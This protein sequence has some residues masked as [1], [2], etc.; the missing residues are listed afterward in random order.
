[1]DPI[2]SKANYFRVCQ[3]LLDKGG[4]ALRAALK[5]S[6]QSMRP[7]SSLASALNANRATLQGIRY[8]I[9]KAP[10][11]DLLFPISGAPDSNNFDITLLTVLLRNICGLSP[12]A[13]GW[14]V[15]PPVSDTSISANILRVKMFRNEVYAHIPTASLDDTTFEKLW[16][17]ISVLLVNLGIPQEDIDDLKV[18]PLSP[19]EESYTERLKEWK[20]QEDD[21][22]SELSDVKSEVVKLRKTVDEKVHH[23]TV[24]W[25]LQNDYLKSELTDVRSEVVKLRKT[26]D[27]N[28]HH[29]TVEKLAKFDFTGKIDGLCKKFH[30]KTRKWLFDKLSS[31]FVSKETRVMIL[32]AGPGA[33]KS[34]LS[35]KISEL[36]RERGQLAAHHFCDFRN[37]DYSNPHRILQSLASQMCDNVDGFRDKLTEIL[38]RENSRD[39]LPDAFRVLLN[40]PLHGL[41]RHDPMLIIVDALDESRTEMKS[42]FLELISE[43][44]SELPKWIKIFIS[45]RPEL[46]VRKVLQHLQPLEIRPDDEDHNQDIELFIRRDLPKLDDDG[47]RSVISKC[48]GSFLYAYHLVHELREKGLGI[49]PDLSDFIPNGIAGY[50]EKQFKRLKIGLQ[51]LKQDTFSSILK[52]FINVIAAAF[53]PLP[54]KILF[55]CMDLPW[56]EFEIR[57]AIIDIMS[58]ILPVYDGCLT[59]YHK[60]LWDWMTLN[61]YEEHAFV[62]D[63]KDGNRRLWRAC[64]KEFCEIKS[65]KS[66]LE[67]QISPENKYALTN[68]GR[69]L[70][71]TGK[72]EEFHWLV[73]VGVNYLTLKF[74]D[75]AT[76]IDLK[77][78]LD[79]YG[80][81]L[82]KDIYY[83]IIQLHSFLVQ[84][85]EVYS[86]KEGPPAYC[87]DYLKALANGYFDFSQ[88]NVCPKNV[89]RNVLDTINEIW[90]EP[91]TNE[92]NH[93]LN[94]V[95]CALSV[96]SITNSLSPDNTM[97]A[98]FNIETWTVQV[99]KIPSLTTLFK[100]QVDEIHGCSY[101]FIAFSPDSSYFLCNS[102]RS[103]VL[104]KE[105]KEVPFIAHGRDD[106]WS[107]SFSSCGTKLA[108]LGRAFIQ[109]WDVIRKTLLAEVDNVYCKPRSRCL[110]SL[111]GS[112]ILLLGLLLDSD[113]SISTNV[114]RSDNLEK[115]YIQKDSVAPCFSSK[116]SIQMYSPHI[117]GLGK[118]SRRSSFRHV[119]LPSGEIVLLSNK[120]CSKTF[121]WKGKKCVAFC[122]CSF[123]S[124]V[125]LIIYDFVN[126]KVVDVFQIECL[127]AM[128]KFDHLSKLDRMKFL[129]HN[130][131]PSLT[132]IIS[133]ESPD[134]SFLDN[135]PID[136][137]ALS[138]D[139]SY[140]ACCFENCILSIRSI[141]SGET[142]QTVALKQRAVACWWSESYLWLV[143]EGV[144]VKYPYEPFHSNILENQTEESI[145]NFS[146]VVKFAKDVLVISTN[147]RI[148]IYKICGENLCHQEIP[149]WV[150]EEAPGKELTSV[151]ISCDGCAV[152]LH[153]RSRKN[154]ELWEIECGNRWF[155]RSTGEFVKSIDWFC[156]TGTNMSRSSVLVSSDNFYSNQGIYVLFSITFRRDGI[157]TVHNHPIRSFRKAFYMDSE[158]VGFFSSGLMHFVD[159]SDARI[160][161]SRN[162]PGKSD[163]LS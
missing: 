131:K 8:N 26:A 133:L 50:Y 25:K 95:S 5:N 134:A 152:M 72:V 146:R 90:I 11:W 73:H 135:A 18:A 143:C 55:T 84:M 3:L 144:V 56:K 105:Q 151:A 139:T 67:F 78:I 31:W 113:S 163:F 118:Q 77:Q 20:Q 136:C 91:V 116:D 138:P 13:T 58:E 21:W 34:V 60:S 4:D 49:E 148:S 53:L 111:C 74:C 35:G 41:H 145:L 82:S 85:G 76:D 69:Y 2:K 108:T 48:E 155:V 44:F 150:L 159:V 147:G 64:E 86:L 158:I 23:S 70:I 10:Q 93:D 98:L 52:S 15:M 127:S 62:A 79:T 43:N 89:A 63:V 54:L 30:E 7:P 68:G 75:L 28:V 94:H 81:V 122:D 45:S 121:L 9:I 37:S 110:F 141:D 142:L 39:S 154:Y 24:E 83:G 22:K 99:L 29:S 59:L 96:D 1:M 32:T 115:V 129:L 101:Y 157:K 80:S 114:L 33:G 16:G 19:G 102:I 125:A 87:D 130:S 124:A 103:C 117:L 140:V 46:Q 153:C 36:Y 51:R 149:S 104:V 132:F 40:D 161:S 160:I 65:L 61:G 92:E 112:Y 66:V 57:T 126:Q 123:A 17:D 128:Y 6:L 137:C 162:D 109:V 97:F 47:I 38:R 88:N 106:I 42:E 119:C 14:N 120:K 12:P 100:I 71:K 107:C 27:E 156:L